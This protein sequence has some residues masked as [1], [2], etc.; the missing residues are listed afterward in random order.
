MIDEGNLSSLIFW[1]LR[2]RNL[3]VVVDKKELVTNAIQFDVSAKDPSDDPCTTQDKKAATGPRIPAI[4]EVLRS[5]LRQVAAEV[6]READPVVG[7][8]E[9]AHERAQELIAEDGQARSAAGVPRREAVAA[10]GTNDQ[11]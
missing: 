10:T 6:G 4:K 1:R 3:V 5:K 8:I 11:V 9:D 7:Q 2:N